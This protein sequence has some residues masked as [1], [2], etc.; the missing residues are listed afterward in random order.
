VTG[1]GVSQDSARS[2]LEI[3]LIVAV[4]QAIEEESVEALRL[5]VSG[6]APVE[7]RGAGFDEKSE[8]GGIPVS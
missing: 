8:R 3:H 5:R 4:Q 7:I 1:F 6:K 2:L